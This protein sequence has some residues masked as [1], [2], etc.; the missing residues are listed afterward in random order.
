MAARRPDKTARFPDDPAGTATA[1]LRRR[2]QRRGDRRDPVLSRQLILSAAQD[3]FAAYGLNGARIDRIAKRVG[4]SKNLIYHYFG[5]KDR[6]YL[7]VLEAIYRQMREDQ[8]DLALQELPPLEGMRRLV[9]NTFDHFVRSPALI[10]LMSIENI[11]FARHLKKSTSVKP[12]YAPLLQTIRS[13]LVRGQEAGVFRRDVDPVDLYISM[14]GLAY[15]YLSNRH[16]LS[17]I[18]DQP[19]DE[20]NRL[21]QRRAHIVEVILGYLQHDGEAVPRPSKYRGNP[22]QT[23]RRA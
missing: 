23:A 19:F 4:A 6:L 1:Q 20:P 22:V 9:A 5:S 3:E 10:R 13:L 8:D 2:R 16:S 12:L 15:F 18:F 17:W 21:E 14:S 11:H 7:K